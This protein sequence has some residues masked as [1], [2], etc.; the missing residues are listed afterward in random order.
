MKSSSRKSK[1]DDNDLRMQQFLDAL[2]RVEKFKEKQRL[3]DYKIDKNQ[4]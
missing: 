1:K 3:K 4:K 2:A